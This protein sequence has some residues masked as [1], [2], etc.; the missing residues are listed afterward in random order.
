MFRDKLT[1]KVW[2]RKAL[3]WWPEIC[4]FAI[5]LLAIFFRLGNHA[6]VDWD[7]SIYALIAKEFIA[8]GDWLTPHWMQ[9]PWFEKP[10][11]FIWCTA[12]LFKW[13]GTTEFCA[14]MISAISGLA[15]LAITYLS[16]RKIDGRLTGILA[17]AV[18][19]S[20]HAFVAWS[21]L[22]TTDMMLSACVLVSLYAFLGVKDEPKWWYIFWLGTAT[23]VMVKSAAGLFPCLV[24]AIV[25]LL[26]RRTK[27]VLRTRQFYRGLSIGILLIAPWH[28]YMY[29]SHGQDFTTMYFGRHIVARAF[30][31]LETNGGDSF[32]YLRALREGMGTLRYFIPLG[33]WYV[34]KEGKVRGNPYLIMVVSTVVV[35]GLATVMRTKLEWY[36]L[37]C[38][39]PL[40]LIIAAALK[41]ALISQNSL[42]FLALAGMVAFSVNEAYFDRFTASTIQTMVLSYGV[43]TLAFGLTTAGMERAFHLSWGEGVSAAMVAILCVCA[44]SRLTFLYDGGQK[45]VDKLAQLAR[46]SAITDPYDGTPVIAFADVE[47][48]ATSFYGGRPHIW[49]ERESEVRDLLAEHGALRIMFSQQEYQRL[50]ADFEIT[51]TAASSCVSQTRRLFSDSIVRSGPGPRHGTSPAR[52]KS[53]NARGDTLC[54][55]AG[56]GPIFSIRQSGRAQLS[57]FYEFAPRR[58]DNHRSRPTERRPRSVRG[59]FH[60]VFG[61]RWP[62]D[63]LGFRG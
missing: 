7:E 50:A 62:V 42:A 52:G 34:L 51:Q 29:F 22:G 27:E 5:A 10:P 9:E 44:S 61:L 12:L 21:R 36:I 32:Y 39:A 33:L 38:Y 8:T 58:R 4:V 46:A 41:R 47:G 19:L 31:V 63:A 59:A 18:L 53:A 45:S 26:D 16:G 3:A 43:I 1:K 49:T 15:L 55:H 2:S 14:R 54:H 57:H 25:S 60:R 40:S 24:A 48:P 56:N 17:A 28:L 6:L 20:T 13:F 37:P 23:G 35:F 11:L 30:T